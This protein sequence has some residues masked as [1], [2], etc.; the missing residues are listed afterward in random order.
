MYILDTLN[1]MAQAAIFANCCVMWC[2][3][4]ADDPDN[5]FENICE[6]A[7]TTLGLNT[8]VLAGYLLAPYF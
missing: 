1:G 5:D 7:F 3:I 4:T 6:L 2:T 8:I